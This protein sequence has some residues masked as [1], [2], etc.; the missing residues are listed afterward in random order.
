M[1]G[2][3]LSCCVN[4]FPGAFWERPRQCRVT[5][6]DISQI[7]FSTRVLSDAFANEPLCEYLLPGTEI[8]RAVFPLL[9]SSIVRA[10][11]MFGEMYTTEG[12]GGSV[13]FVSRGE[14]FRF[15]PLARAVIA[16]APLK[17]SSA[18]VR[19]CV[20]VCTRLDS[21]HER[22]AIG[23]HWYVMFLGLK[24]SK[25][26]NATAV[27]RSLLSRADSARMPCYLETFRQTDLSFFED[28]GF[29]IEGA[30]NLRAGGPSFWAMLRLPR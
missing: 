23:P 20:H 25:V 16:T 5:R 4:K 27:L 6:G 15:E 11:Q 2:N 10:S 3:H 13:A 14:Q 12:T 17:L 1:L 7:D 19:R 8:Q 28:F 21:A 18:T 24:A 29:R 22:L 26:G 9:F 30:G